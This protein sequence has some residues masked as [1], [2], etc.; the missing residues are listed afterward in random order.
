VI[1]ATLV[2][3]AACAL[4][5]H[6]ERRKELRHQT[7]AKVLASLAFIAVAL[8]ALHPAS[9]FKHWIL[10]GLCVS[11]LGDVLLVSYFVVG[12]LLFF[13]GYL[14]YCVALGKLLAPGA[15]ASHAGNYAGVPVAIATAALVALWPKL[16]VLRI[17][18][19]CYSAA[20]VVMSIAAIAVARTPGLLPTW[21]GRFLY[22]SSALF[23]ASDFAAARHVILKAS[24]TNRAWGL[25][26]YYAA[27]LL[28]A[29]S[30]AS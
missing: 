5:V 13:A 22:A 15:W 26:A 18:A 14:A 8:L 2:C 3:I 10:I 9:P 16:G 12:Q 1:F 23:F 28:V 29:W 30:L 4:R 11:A 17:P 24:F 6:V 20:I 27:Q 21:N 25:S 7:L 19:V